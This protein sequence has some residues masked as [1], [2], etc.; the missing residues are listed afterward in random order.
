MSADPLKDQL[1]RI[2]ELYNQGKSPSQ[3]DFDALKVAFDENKKDIETFLS[4]LDT[5]IKKPQLKLIK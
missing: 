3:S 2:T 5:Y 1:E 4:A